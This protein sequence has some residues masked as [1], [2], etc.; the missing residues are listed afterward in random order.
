M[1][2]WTDKKQINGVITESPSSCRLSSET[3]FMKESPFSV[4]FQAS[5]I[6]LIFKKN[7]G[8]IPESP[9]SCRRS[10]ESE[11]LYRTRHLVLAFK[12]V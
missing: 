3:G 12:R 8:V 2:D 7:N 5:L 6:G 11:V 9:G 1:S 4:G 10:S